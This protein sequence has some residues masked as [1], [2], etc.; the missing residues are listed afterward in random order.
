VRVGARRT[1]ELAIDGGAATVEIA[2]TLT[3]LLD[4]R[5][6]RLGVLTQLDG[7]GAWSASQG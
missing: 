6:E 1:A 2:E 3:V 7:E 4:V 5:I